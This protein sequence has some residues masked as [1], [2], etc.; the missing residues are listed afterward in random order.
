MAKQTSHEAVVQYDAEPISLLDR[1]TARIAKNYGGSVCGDSFEFDA[2]RQHRR[3]A[4]SFAT[5]RV[6]RR[7]VRAMEKFLGSSDFGVRVQAGED[8]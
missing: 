2:K 5:K 6:A 8:E 4:Y 7:F 3:L 1:N